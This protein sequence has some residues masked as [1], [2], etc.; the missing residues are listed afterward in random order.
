MAKIKGTEAWGRDKARKLYADGGLIAQEAR[1]AAA[2]RTRSTRSMPDAFPV[3]GMPKEDSEPTFGA[4]SSFLAKDAPANVRKVFGGKASGGRL[5]RLPRASGGRADDAL[6]EGAKIPK[7]GSGL[8]PYGGVKGAGDVI[9][10]DK[11][12]PSKY[13]RSPASQ[14]T[15]KTWKEMGGKEEDYQRG[16]RKK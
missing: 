1:D 6:T 9:N 11:R 4:G 16:G 12:Y 15:M 5:D 8:A 2:K 7:G 14:N 13:G 3:G 10:T